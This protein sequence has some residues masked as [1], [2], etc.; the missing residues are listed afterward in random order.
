MVIHLVLLKPRPDLSAAD[1][2]AF[3]AAFARATAEIPEVRGVRFGRRITHGAGYEAGVPDAA[4]YLAILEFDDVAGLRAYLQH[5]A[6]RDVG[7]RFGGSVSS[8]LIYDFE[9]VE[10]LEG[11][12]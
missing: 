10:G 7:D 9:W 4:D 6:H 3:V 2:Q 1:R 8:A 12:L 5:P 11:L